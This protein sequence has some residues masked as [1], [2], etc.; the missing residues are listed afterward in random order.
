MSKKTQV[1][2]DRLKQLEPISAL[3]DARLEELVSLSYVDRVGLG[4]SLFR[5]GDVDNQTIYLLDGDVQMTSSDGRIDKLISSRSQEA[6][7]PLD[8]SQPRQA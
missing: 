4:V 5:E 1:S 7:F 6:H 3:S 2:V 8:D